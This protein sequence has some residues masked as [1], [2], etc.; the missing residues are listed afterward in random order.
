MFRRSAQRW[1]ITPLFISRYE[2]ALTDVDA[3]LGQPEYQE[4]LR[5]LVHYKS[6]QGEYSVKQSEME[7]TRRVANVCGL[8]VTPKKRVPKPSAGSPNPES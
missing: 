5:K 3:G 2:Q 1:A 6:L 8:D 4:L 7:R